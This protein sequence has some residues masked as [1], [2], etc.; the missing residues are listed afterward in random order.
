MAL[1]TFNPVASNLYFNF[2]STLKVFNSNVS[3]TVASLSSSPMFSPASDS[4]AS[5]SA[6]TSFS[7]SDSDLVELVLVELVSAVLLTY[8][9]SSN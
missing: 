5:S 6:G 1:K 2:F 9:V 4:A 8:L 3:S 7:P